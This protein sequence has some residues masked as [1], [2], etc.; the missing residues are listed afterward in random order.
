M[1]TRERWGY[2]HQVGLHDFFFFGYIH[3]LFHVS[4]FLS[5]TQ[6]S[7]GGAHRTLLWT[8]DPPLNAQPTTNR[9]EDA[10]HRELHII[11]LPA[12]A[13]WRA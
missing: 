1:T 8:R 10:V 11:V 3:F 12:N 2:V 5:Q 9:L 6:E 4:A 13:S 7:A